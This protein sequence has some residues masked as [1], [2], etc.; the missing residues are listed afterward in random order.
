MEGIF[1]NHN[2]D[3]FEIYGFDYG[4]FHND[5]THERIKKYFDKFYYINDLQDE[6]VAEIVKENK[7]DIAIHRNGYSQ[8]SRNSLFAKKIAPIQISFLGYPGT[9]GVK[10]IDYIIADKVV[11]PDKNKQFFLE[12]I[13]YLPNT[14]YPTNNERVISEKRY[15]KIDLGIDDKSFVFGCFNNSYKI[16]PNEFTIWMKLLDKIKNSVLVLLINDELTKKNLIKEI[17]KNNQDPNRVKFLNFIEN[18]DHLARHKLI[19]LYLDTFNYN[20][21]TSS[22]DALFTGVPVLT[23]IGKSFT[24]RVCTSIIQSFEMPELITSS[25]QEYY[26]QAVEIATN[27]KKFIKLKLDVKNKIKETALFDTK[28]YVKN[29][30]TAYSLALNNRVIQNKVDHITF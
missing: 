2:K 12:K 1:K 9:M 16:S 23:K 19:D 13:I 7:I 22:I 25:E 5:E 28:K 15:K 6:K 18:K 27:K 24:S 14:Y 21:H 10:F 11:I 26:E 30:E 17:K 8:S 3:K 4:N 29:L 20:G